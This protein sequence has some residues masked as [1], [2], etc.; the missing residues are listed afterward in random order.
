LKESAGE[1]LGLAAEEM[2]EG[3]LFAVDGKG[4]VSP[5]S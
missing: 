2:A 3:V 5:F 4:V 1:A